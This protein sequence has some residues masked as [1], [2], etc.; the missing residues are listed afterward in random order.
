MAARA[1]GPKITATQ[2]TS[3][4]ATEQFFSVIPTLAP[5]E[6]THCEVDCN[7]P[8]GPTDNLVVSVYTTLDDSSPNWDDTA[9]LQFQIDKGTD[10]NKASFIVTGIYRFRIGVKASGATDTITSADF[11]MRR[12]AVL[13]GG[14]VL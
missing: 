1:W 7:F 13:A 8:G 2:L 3:I 4:T 6:L 14:T 9:F 12:E 10:P 5:G 11:A